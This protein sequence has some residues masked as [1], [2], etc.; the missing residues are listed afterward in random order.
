L[1]TKVEGYKCDVCGTIYE[2]KEEAEECEES[3][4]GEL[5]YEPV[6]TLGDPVPCMVK[7]RVLVDGVPIWVYYRR[8]MT[9]G[10]ADGDI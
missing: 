7:V 10:E 9:D 2:S 1:V 4:R 8:V 6:F 5:T 3:H